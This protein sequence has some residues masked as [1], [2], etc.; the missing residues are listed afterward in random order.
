MASGAISE[1]ARRA[2]ERAETLL[3]ILGALAFTL[4][5]AGGIHY[6]DWFP[7]DDL[8]AR[9][10]LMGGGGLAFAFGA[11]AAIRDREPRRPHGIKIT[12]PIQ[13]QLVDRVN[14][15][16]SMARRPPK[17][18]ALWVVRIYRGGDLVPLRK[19][20][21]QVNQRKWE[22]K[23][24]DVG[25]ETGQ[26]RTLGVFLVGPSTQKFFEYFKSAAERHNYWMDKLNVPKGEPQRY[27]PAIEDPTEDMIECDRVDVKRS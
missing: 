11:Y 9:I 19:A 16:G 12:F 5:A 1:I 14:V 22:A 6:K 13:G 27:L 20:S 2:F 3:I 26:E 25:G 15:Q 17:R 8:A 21:L 10:A 18:Y 4:G 24:C 23:E 7:I